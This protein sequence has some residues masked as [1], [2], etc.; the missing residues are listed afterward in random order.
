MNRL[1]ADV[2]GPM[3]YLDFGGPSDAPLMILVHGLGASS[4][5]WS[6]LARRMTDDYRVVAPDLVGFGHTA[7]DRRGVTVPDNV[8]H[9]ARFIQQVADGPVTLVGNSMGGMISV[10]T[11][12][13]RPELVDSLALIN[14]ALPGRLS[15]GALRNVDRRIALFFAAYNMPFV[16]Q[17]FLADR[18][19]RMTP[20]RQVALLLD[21]ICVDP[22]RVNP[23]LVSQLVD[24]ATERRAYTWSD[25]AFLGA[26]RSIM[27][28][29]TVGRKQY[30][31][32]LD[33][34]RLPTLLVHGEQDRLVPIAAARLLVARNP[35]IPLV[36]L[37][38]VGHA[39]QLEVPDQLAKSLR[40][41]HADVRRDA[42]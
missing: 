39:P 37:S 28:V 2:D 29:L 40:T 15:P 21:T 23:D 27:R 16:A 30:L 36:A 34:L 14:P 22:T 19:R 24:Q 5:S 6:D 26:V 7:P 20:A 33:G 32:I 17:R 3:H 18:R 10:L 41:W 12:D 25:D 42:A 13:S 1:I 8:A 31:G 4:L 35:H 9:L 11:Q 38:D